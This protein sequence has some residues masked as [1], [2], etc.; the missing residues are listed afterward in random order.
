MSFTKE[1]VRRLRKVGHVRFINAPQTLAQTQFLAEYR[2]ATIAGLTPRGTP[3]LHAR[4]LDG[5]PTLRGVAIPTTGFDWL[6]EPLLVNRGIELRHIPDY[7]T[8][9][10][11]EFTWGLILSLARRIPSAHH[12]MKSGRTTSIP[13]KGIELRGKTLGVIGLGKIGSRV[14]RFGA[15]FGMNVQAT[16]CRDIPSSKTPLIPLR[17]LLRSSDFLSIHIPYSRSTEGLLSTPELSIMKP[18]GFLVNTSRPDIVAPKAVLRQ[19]NRGLLSGYALDVGYWPKSRYPELRRHERVLAV[20]HM[21]WFTREAHLR[22]MES[23]T[24]NLINLAL[25]KD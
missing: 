2:N 16:D 23:W 17:R 18:G 21:S 11:A 5:I 13:L 10:A 22:A 24:D 15:A 20:P 1:Q 6:N 9:S 3:R 12:W 7:A 14:A 8:D 4:L 25:N 19:L